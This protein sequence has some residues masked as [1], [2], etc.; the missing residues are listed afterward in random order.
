MNESDETYVAIKELG[1]SDIMDTE[2]AT[3]IYSFESF[4]APICF[5]T[6]KSDGQRGSLQFT[7]M[8]RYYFGF[9]ERS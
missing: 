8:P 2:Q 5:V 6:R 1:Y 7:H 9:K 4:L 3:T